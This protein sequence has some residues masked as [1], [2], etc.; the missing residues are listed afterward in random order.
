MAEAYDSGIENHPVFRALPEHQHRLIKLIGE[1]WSGSYRWPTFDYVDRT[2]RQDT[3]GDTLATLAQLPVVQGQGGYQPYGLVFSA[4]GR[5]WGN[6]E[7]RLGLT[8]AGMY[9][10]PDLRNYMKQLVGAI[11]LAAQIEARLEPDPDAVVDLNLTVDT[12]CSMMGQL[13]SL[14]PPEH[15]AA[16]LEREPPLAFA[17][18]SE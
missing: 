6:P 17:I 3:G 16:A 9:Y 13:A 8:I 4:D 7:S 18:R 10:L 11:D 5:G 12:L 2:F 14:W 1:Q 15:L